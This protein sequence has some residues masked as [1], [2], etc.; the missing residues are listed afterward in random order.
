M[1][2]IIEEFTP[3]QVLEK[4]LLYI[5]YLRV[6]VRFY[7]GKLKQGK[8]QVKWSTLLL[9]RRNLQKFHSLPQIFYFMR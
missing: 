1:V 6:R 7:D 2:Y 9:S 4:R 3:L 5:T 8:L